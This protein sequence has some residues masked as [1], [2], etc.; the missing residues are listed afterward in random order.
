MRTIL[1]PN[2][3]LVASERGRLEAAKVVASNPE[4]RYRVESMYGKELCKK[5]WPEAYGR[6]QSGGIMRMFRDAVHAAKTLIPVLLVAFLVATGITQAQEVQKPRIYSG[7][8]L[9]VKNTAGYIFNG[10]HRVT[11]AASTGNGTA[12]AD[13][14]TSC[15]APTYSACNFLIASNAGTVSVTQTLSTAA[16]TANTLLALIETTGGAITRIV[17]ANMSDTI[18]SAALGQSVAF[19]ASPLPTTAGNIDIGSTAL[20][21]QSIY[22]GNAATNNLRLLPGTTAA[23]RTINLCDPIATAVCFSDPSVLTQQLKI[24]LGSATGA[25]TFTIGSSAARTITFPDV[26]GNASVAYINPTSSQSISGIGSLTSTTSNAA[27]AGVLRLANTE[28]VNWR[29]AAN[30]AD[31]GLSVDASN[32]LQWNGSSPTDGY[33]FV[34]PEQC[35]MALTTGVFAA[36]PANSGALTAPALVRAASSNSVLQLVTTGAANTTDVV[37]DFTPP[38]RLTSGKGITINSIGYLF[39]YQTTALTS[40]GTAA[41]NSITYAAPGS[42]AGTVA[43]AGGSLTPVGG[44]NHGT[45][46]VVTTTGQCY[47]EGLTFGTPYAVVTDRVRLV[48]QNTFVQSAASATTMQIC[49]TMVYYTINKF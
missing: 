8:G 41:V 29:N 46:P 23:A 2:E 27:S 37:C 6:P 13:T 25:T 49:G 26:G 11:I 34:G 33:Y 16:N 43:A 28:A 17:S 22:L 19:S 5:R 36:N 4:A 20:P 45:P 15:A 30:N 14:Q 21:W 12:L 44:I 1:T 24:N 47:N 40:I 7:T 42:A 35:S 9:F 48:W 3:F 10:G 38:S 39:G 18:S 31:I 32:F